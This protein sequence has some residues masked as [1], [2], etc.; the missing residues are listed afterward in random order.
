MTRQEDS[1]SWLSNQGYN[2][3]AKG[4]SSLTKKFELD[5]GEVDLEG[6]KRVLLELEYE[7]EEAIRKLGLD[8]NDR[9]P[10]HIPG[11][12]T[13]QNLKPLV[14]GTGYTFIDVCGM[15]GAG[16]NTFI[17]KLVDLGDERIVSTPEAFHIVKSMN[18]FHTGDGLADQQ[19]LLA[20][21]MAQLLIGASA[22]PERD[23][24]GVIVLNRSFSDNPV[25]TRAR[26]LYGDL[27]IRPLASQQWLYNLTA[28]NGATGVI[29]CMI[30]PAQSLERHHEEGIGRYRN[31]E[32]LDLLYKEYLRLIYEVRQRN[33]EN[34]AVLD[35]S[36]PSLKDNFQLFKETFGKITG[37]KL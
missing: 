4:F 26:L 13:I 18:L 36:G 2:I 11:I 27:D 9:T 22:L 16:K 31:P 6:V 14:G 30:P 32:F 21:L 25:F 10:S 29:L 15:M 1:R 24:G 8:L 12:N 34:F 20:S 35:T 17:Q 37:K 28:I 19:N 3:A 23:K 5:D 33:Q 7:T